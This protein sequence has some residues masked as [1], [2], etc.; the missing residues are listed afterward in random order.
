MERGGPAAPSARRA[1]SHGA[2]SAA[3][4]GKLTRPNPT[5]TAKRGT[6]YHVVVASDGLPLVALPPLP[7]CTT[8][9]CFPPCCA[10]LWWYTP[11]LPGSTPMPHRPRRELQA[12]RGRGHPATHPR[13]GRTARVQAVHRSLCCRACKCLAARQQAPRSA[14]R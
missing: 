6:K 8:R 4:R 14:E 5:D 13:K 1:H 9:C 12:L 2:L 3:S 11:P 7:T 10:A